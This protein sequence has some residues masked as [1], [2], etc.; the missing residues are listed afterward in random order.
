MLADMPASHEAEAEENRGW[1]IRC[2]SELSKISE[3]KGAAQA[4]AIR[5]QAAIVENERW[6]TH[7]LPAEVSASRAGLQKSREW[8]RQVDGQI[9]SIQDSMEKLKHDLVTARERARMHSYLAREASAEL[10]WV[11]VLEQ[12]LT[13]QPSLAT[14]INSEW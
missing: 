5:A 12:R 10:T 8:R 3:A 9:R 4:E 6:A 13:D 2:E 7:A 14:A 11:K 1:A